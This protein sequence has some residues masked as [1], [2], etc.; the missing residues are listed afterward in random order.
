MQRKALIDAGVQ[1]EAIELIPDEV[2]ATDEALQRAR[3]GD[4]VL[5]FG[6]VIE[7]CWNQ[8][9]SF[10]S[11]TLEPGAARKKTPPVQRTFEAPKAPSMEKQRVIRDERGV[12][13]AREQE[14]SD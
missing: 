3:A 2:E 13:L 6:D 14:T 10:K 9:T 11:G 1:P 7:R 4:L 12:R 5:I 8:I